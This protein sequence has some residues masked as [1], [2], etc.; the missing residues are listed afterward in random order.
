[1]EEI[2][3]F[4][5]EDKGLPLSCYHDLFPLFFALHVFKLF[6]VVDLEVS[7]FFSAA[8]ADVRLKA[9]FQR[10]STKS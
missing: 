10:A 3:T 2:V 1:M 4:V 8:F 5:A 9:L 7:P 6:D